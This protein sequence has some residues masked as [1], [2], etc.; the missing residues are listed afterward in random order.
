MTS[1]VDPKSFVSRGQPG[2]K[3]VL[4]NQHALGVETA[5]PQ[6]VLLAVTQLT[7]SKEQVI[8]PLRFRHGANGQNRW[9][10][11]TQRPVAVDVPDRLC[12]PPEFCIC[13]RCRSSALPF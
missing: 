3:G 9:T 8:Q 2:S 1:Q 6:A 5:C 12:G 7:N 10:R 11:D 13:A 4:D